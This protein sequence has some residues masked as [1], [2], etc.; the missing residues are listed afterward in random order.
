MTYDQTVIFSLF[1]A[2]FL[3]LLW[4]RFQSTLPGNNPPAVAGPVAQSP[5][6]A[7]TLVDTGQHCDGAERGL[8]LRSV[9]EAIEPSYGTAVAPERGFP[10]GPPPREE[11]APAQPAGDD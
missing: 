7:A 1:G 8:V 3:L 10:P 11:A 6:R 2:V 9:T 4:G 5:E